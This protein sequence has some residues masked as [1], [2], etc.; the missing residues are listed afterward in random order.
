MALLAG[1]ELERL[2]AERALRDSER[3]YRS[4]FENMLNGFAY[5]RVL[6]EQGQAQDFIYLSVNN[7][8]DTLTGLGQ[9]VG[10]KVSEVIPGIREADP[11][12]FEIY[13]RVALSGIPEHVEIYVQ[14]LRRWFSIAVYSPSLEHIVVVFDEI[15]ERKKTELE[16]RIAAIAFEAQEGIMV[17]DADTVIMRVNRAFTE[18]TGYTVEDAVGKKPNMLKSGYNDTV[19][20]GDMWL[21]IHRDG[22]WQGEIWNRRKTGETFPGWLTI[23]AVAGDDGS[24]T[25]YVGTLTDITQRKDA[26]TEIRQLAFFDPLTGLPNRRLLLDRL[27]QAL[28]TS[29]RSQR[30]GALLFIDLDNFKSLN[31][32]HG[33]DQ[34][35]LLLKQ[36]AQRIVSCVREVDTVARMGGDE[37]VIML[38]NLSGSYQEA[39]VQAERVGGKILSTLNQPYS[40][41]KCEHRS[42]TSIGVTL[43]DGQKFTVGELLKQ[44]D[45]AMYQA[46]VA[47]RNTLRLF[48]LEM[49]AA[50]EARLLLE[51]SLREGLRR[52]Q[53][54]LYYQPQVDCDGCLTGAEALVRWQHPRHGLMP[55]GEFISLAEETGLILPLGNWVLETVCRQLADWSMQKMAD[56]L[57]LAVNVS[58][59]QFHCPDFVERVI[60]VLDKTGAN[61]RRLR[62]EL[63]ES[64]LLDNV[65]ESIAKM[66]ELKTKGVTFALDDF[67]VGYSSLRYLQLLPL[68]QL[69]IDVSF[70]RDALTDTNDAAIIRTI[71]AL[72]QTLGLGVIAEGVETKAQ[73]DL[74]AKLGCHAFQGYLFGIPLPVEALWFGGQK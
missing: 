32:N 72:G 57:T 69:K 46:K 34:G 17:T 31:D 33:H 4:L 54:I 58:A 73:C 66:T 8:F 22:K 38:E 48:N 27:H 3:L 16:L 64:L 42:S 2:E 20:F 14:A 60:A 62:F 10:K 40:L 11:E 61:P 35:D 50:S 30:Q 39:I 52:D 15:S 67:G 43:F 74:L 12:L 26:E 9:V 51:E 18:I 71:V 23:T 24:I 63:T 37:F 5:C 1:A 36:V 47:G 70:V 45:L 13:A 44:A 19:F 6:F 49:L 68:D 59:R 53:F 41:G 28:L 7:A 56:E 65:D 55:P 29:A 21:G 25:H